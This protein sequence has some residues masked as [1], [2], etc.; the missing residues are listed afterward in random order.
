MSA[1]WRNRGIEELL[2]HSLT[3]APSISIVGMRQI[4]KSSLTKR[5]SAQYHTFDSAEFIGRLNRERAAILQPGPYPIGLDEVQKFPQIFDIIKM[6]IDHKRTP[7][8]FIL[9]GLVRF[10]SKKNIR[11]SLTGR[12]VVLEMFP[13]TLAE[14]HKQK[15]SDFLHRAIF[16]TDTQFNCISE[17]TAWSKF[18]HIEG[19]L[20]KGG[21]PGIFSQR[22]EKVRYQMFSQHLDTLL[23]RDIQFLIQTK[24]EVSALRELFYQIVA[25]QG[26]PSNLST[27]SRMFGYSV[28]TMRKII[29]AMVGLY[30]IRSHGNTFYVEDQGLASYAGETVNRTEISVLEGFVYHELRVQKSLMPNSVLKFS[31]FATRGGARVPFV[32]ERSKGHSIAI[33]VTPEKKVTEKNLKSLRSYQKQSK[34]QSRLIALHSGDSAYMSSRDIFCLPVNAI[35]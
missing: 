28:P 13:F 33:T 4:G 24:M 16:E 5:F 18:S 29:D 30:L 1:H 3:W 34:R 26:L 20:S 23:G 35:V 7:G 32:F 21:L 27:L 12:N 15:V 10:A 11:E 8:R 2:K 22:E 14:C 19:Y 17:A 9:T 31:A 25:L 6:M